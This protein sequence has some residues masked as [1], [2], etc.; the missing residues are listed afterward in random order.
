MCL[1]TVPSETNW[2]Y[3]H[4]N[5]EIT[6]NVAL[7]GLFIT[8][9]LTG[10]NPE[11]GESADEDLHKG[12]HISEQNPM[13][14]QYN[15]HPIFLFGGSSNDNL[16]QNDRLTEELDLLDS[17]GGNFVRGNLSWR[18]SGNV[19]PYEMINGQYDLNRFN[20]VYWNR[21]DGFVKEAEQR[22]II[23][24]LEVWPTV[25]FHKFNVKGWLDN[26]FNPAMNSN[27]SVQESGLP[28]EHD[29]FHWEKL[30]PFFESVQGLSNDNPM[31]RRYQERF[32]D[33]VLS[34]TL[35]VNNIGSSL[36]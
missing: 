17:L 6:I 12:I 27:Y 36:E 34:Y 29:Y 35:S 24:Q 22:E 5:K 19:K 33:K 31:V 7:L 26:P 18:D 25:D 11:T 10:C 16:H 15:G 32:V 9:V 20:D 30:N 1:Y 14:W 8:C 3:E 28:A 13:Y 4:M 23:I 2:F 21:L